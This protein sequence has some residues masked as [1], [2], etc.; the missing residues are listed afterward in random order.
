MRGG[1]KRSGF[2]L[3]GTVLA[4][5]LLVLAILAVVYVHAT[6]QRVLHDKRLTDEAVV[7]EAVRSLTEFVSRYPAVAANPWPAEGDVPLDEFCRLAV[8]L[9]ATPGTCP[10]N[11]R[12][13]NGK[14]LVVHRGAKRCLVSQSV[15]GE[16]VQYF[17]RS[18]LVVRVDDPHLGT[19]SGSV[20]VEEVLGQVFHRAVETLDRVASAV[21]SDAKALLATNACADVAVGNVVGIVG[22]ASC[23]YYCAPSDDEAG[24]LP[25][26][27]VL[28]VVARC[29]GHLPCTAGHSASL[30][31]AVSDPFERAVLESLTDAGEVPSAEC[32]TSE[33]TV[34]GGNGTSEVVPAEAVGVT[35][36]D[37]VVAGSH[38]VLYDNSNANNLDEEPYSFRL[39]FVTPWGTQFWQLYTETF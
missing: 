20:P 13:A 18:E 33:V 31:E 39:G 36:D 2:V 11:L 28:D 24:C 29:A 5:V 26:R 30:D 14:P 21:I 10:G 9:G 17:C 8:Q 16:P 3:T 38:C 23:N 25:H 22:R 32:L 35:A 27:S 19:F 15:S 12:D 37:A 4:V 1:L 6:V 34:A 7:R